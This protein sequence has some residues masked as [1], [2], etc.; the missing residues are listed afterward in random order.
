MLKKWF[1]WACET[2]Y[3]DGTGGYEKNNEFHGFEDVLEL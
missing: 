1:F 3:E 2:G